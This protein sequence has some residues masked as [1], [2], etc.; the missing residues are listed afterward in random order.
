MEAK[1]V[2]VT[3]YASIDNCLGLRVARLWSR[4]PKRASANAK[5]NPW[6]N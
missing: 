1:E 4:Q 6:P 5:K 3:Y 2:T